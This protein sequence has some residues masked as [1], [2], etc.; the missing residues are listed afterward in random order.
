LKQTSL[1]LLKTQVSQLL[2]M[3]KQEYPQVESERSVKFPSQTVQ[4]PFPGHDVQ[5]DAMQGVQ[6]MIPS[7]YR[8]AAH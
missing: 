4:V 6:A 1:L 3:L 2:M 8:P 5:L 7:E